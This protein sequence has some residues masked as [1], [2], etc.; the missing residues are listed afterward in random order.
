MALPPC[1]GNCLYGD[2]SWNKQTFL[3]D[4]SKCGCVKCPYFEICGTWAP[5]W[6]FDCH[7]G[8]CVNC[9]MGSPTCIFRE[10]DTCVVCAEVRTHIKLPNCDHFLCTVCA[11]KIYNGSDGEF[12]ISVAIAN[13]PQCP[14]GCV[15][16]PRGRQCGCTEYGDLLEDWFES[17]TSDVAM[18]TVMHDIS[19]AFGEQGGVYN[20]Q[21]CPVCRA[22]GGSWYKWG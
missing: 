3:Y 19:V 1:N 22:E 7:H 4:G 5:P 13:G 18:Y 9:A 21:T 14:N 12:D 20:S 11:R 8:T 6:Y 15:N 10:G 16:P 2:A 17:K